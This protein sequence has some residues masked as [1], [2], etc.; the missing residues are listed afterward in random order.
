VEKNQGLRKTQ[1]ILRVRIIR[2]GRKKT[3]DLGGTTA[4]EGVKGGGWKGKKSPRTSKTECRKREGAWEGGRRTRTTL[5]EKD[6][7]DGLGV[8]REEKEQE[9]QEGEGKGQRQRP[10][11][12]QEQSARR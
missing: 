1:S 5:L 11:A 12:S 2:P 7:A 10:K 8:K 9:F 3:G 6:W 4:G